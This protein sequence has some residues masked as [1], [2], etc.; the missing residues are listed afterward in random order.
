MIQDL[1]VHLVFIGYAIGV[2]LTF[3]TVLTWV[4]RTQAAFMADRIGA[5][6]AYV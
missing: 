5:N 6:R 4:E 1:A 3:G 2:L